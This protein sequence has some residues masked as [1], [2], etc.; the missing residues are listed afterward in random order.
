[1]TFTPEMN[2]VCKLVG[3]ADDADDADGAVR[4]IIA[5]RDEAIAER[6]GLATTLE[7]ARALLTRV[8]DESLMTKHWGA[9]T[10]RLSINST[11]AEIR[12]ALTKDTSNG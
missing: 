1:M 9:D 3:V 2:K 12:A 8:H 4:R 10:L 5:E 11:V 7:S 6:D